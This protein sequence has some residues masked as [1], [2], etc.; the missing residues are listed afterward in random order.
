MAELKPCPFCGCTDIQYLISGHF[1][2]WGGGAGIRLWYHCSCYECGAEIDTGSCHT[3]KE[4][5]REW[6]RRADARQLCEDCPDGC[7]VETPK[8]SRNVV[9]NADRIR[10]MNDEEL[11]REMLFFVPSDFNIKHDYNRHYTGIAGGYYAT[12]EEAIRANFDWLQQP[13]KEE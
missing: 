9:T 13:A 3:L 8:D 12:A 2:P 1:Q 10:S 5:A 4:A 6:N 11:A 7:P